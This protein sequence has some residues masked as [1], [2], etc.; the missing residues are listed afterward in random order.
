MPFTIQPAV[1]ADYDA[2]IE[3]WEASVRASHHFLPEDDI[4]FFKPLI[5]QQY[6]QAVDLYCLRSP[7]DQISGFLG[8]SEDKIEMLFID[9]AAFGR[10]YG[11]QLLDF[12]VRDRKIRKVDVNEQNSQ[13]VAFYQKMG[14]R[15][16][17]RD[18]FDGM[19]KPYPILHLELEPL[20]LHRCDSGHPDFITLV[21]LLDA[22]L[23]VR[24]GADH[25]FYHQFNT[26]AALQ[27]CVVAY[28]GDRAAGC[29]AFKPF[30]AGSVE[31][32]RMYVL[33][34]YRGRGVAAA[35]LQELETWARDSGVLHCV[36][37]TGKK[38][39]E[40]IALYR[41]SGYQQIPNYGQY[42]GIENS[43]CFRK[44]IAVY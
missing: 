13:A 10:G 35:V 42:A 17:S 6:L 12:A 39:P 7:E 25:A 28:L 16:V 24:D 18:P 36:L 8:L 37:E 29:G 38:Q 20:R 23:A 30:D 26:I 14:F 15:T 4:L 1:E 5:R 40:A 21:R 9:P 11:R 27:H 19:G 2:I 33:P 34:E 3:L 31:I 44:D 41:K 43:V 22:D 32:K